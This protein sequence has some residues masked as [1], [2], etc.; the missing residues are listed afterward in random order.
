MQYGVSDKI[1]I[2]EAEAIRFEL[3]LTAPAQRAA[4]TDNLRLSTHANQHHMVSTRPE[5]VLRA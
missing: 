4:T 3:S 1:F 2:P 5:N